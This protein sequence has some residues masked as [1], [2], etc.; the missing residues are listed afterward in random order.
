MPPPR[1]VPPPA[2]T[3]DRCPSLR[4]LQHFHEPPA[5]V[6]GDRARL[7]ETH[8]VAHLALVLLVVDL[9]LGPPTH[10]TTVRRVLHQALDG[11]HDGLL[12]AVADHP[13]DPDLP[14]IT[15]LH[16]RHAPFHLLDPDSSR[17][18]IT[19]AREPGDLRPACAPSPPAP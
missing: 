10:V 8:E 16:L 3:R 15:R 18:A 11:D 6:L 1:G 4:P 14:A 2:R 12:H 5:L 19:P 7:H 17:R 9:E 13:A